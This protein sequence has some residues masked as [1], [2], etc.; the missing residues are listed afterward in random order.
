[1][2]SETELDLARRVIAACRQRGLQVVTAESCTGGL[3]AAA[4][5]E[6]AGASEVLERG[7]VTYSNEA[8]TD[9]LGVPP[10]LVATHGAVSEAV[11]RRMAEGALEASSA[12]LAVSVT[13]VAGPGG[14]EAKPEGLVHFASALRDG[15]VRHQCREFGPLGRGRVR[16]ESVRQ[17][18]AMLLEA[19]GAGG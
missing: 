13:G 16:A 19:A 2:V 11:A 14:S 3:T 6:I 12:G 1:M 9:L 5:T 4:L 8:K 7:F 17:A 10:E 15:P 18:L